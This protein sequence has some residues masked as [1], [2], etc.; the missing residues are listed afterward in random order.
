MQWWLIFPMIIGLLTVG[1]NYY[2][3]Y[4]ADNSPVDFIYA[5]T[6]LIWSIV[7]ITSWEKKQEWEKAI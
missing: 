2:F 7:F 5:F 1:I 6:V 3:D 4:T